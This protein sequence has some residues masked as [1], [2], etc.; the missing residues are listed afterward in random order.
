VFTININDYYLNPNIDGDLEEFILRKILIY[1]QNTNII[2]NT[3]LLTKIAIMDCIDGAI[4]ENNEKVFN[5][6][7]NLLHKLNIERS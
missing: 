7:I 2:F 3:E 6:L 4:D 1:I 5:W